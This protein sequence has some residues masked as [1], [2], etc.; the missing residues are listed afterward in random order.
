MKLQIITL[1]QIVKDNIIGVEGI[2]TH[3]NI[4]PGPII[5]YLFQPRGINPNT[6]APASHVITYADRIVGGKWEE[7]DVPM[8]ILGSNAEDVGTGFK[9]KVTSLIYHMGNCLHIAI[10]PPG[11]SPDTGNA[12]E[13]CEFDIRRVKGPK[14]KMLTPKDLKEDTKKTPSPTMIKKVSR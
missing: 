12:F 10:K 5:E 3:I 4:L 13:S 11:L 14:I 2:L 9:G 1:G 6:N 8:E 7:L